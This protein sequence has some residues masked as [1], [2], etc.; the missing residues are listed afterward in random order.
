MLTHILLRPS[1]SQE[2]ALDDASKVTRRTRVSFERHQSVLMEDLMDELEQEF[3][4][5]SIDSIDDN[6]IIESMLG[7][8]F[9][10][11]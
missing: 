11:Q 4:D 6:D 7:R 8:S 1:Q 5:L 3:G 10:R 2:G 9:S